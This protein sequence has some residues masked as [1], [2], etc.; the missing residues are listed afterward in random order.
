MDTS[1]LYAL[2]LALVPD[3]DAAET[4]FATARDEADLRRRAAAWREEQGLPPAAA[5]REEQGLPPAAADP[6]LPAVHPDDL[7]HALRRRVRLQRT[8]RL[9]PWLL[10]GGVALVLGALALRLALPPPAP[11]GMAA[12]PVFAAASIASSPTDSGLRFSVYRV[13]AGPQQVEAWWE[14]S[15]PGAGRSGYGLKPELQPVND[16]R[17]LAPQSAR[18]QAVGNDRLLGYSTYSSLLP[19]PDSIWLHGRLPGEGAG[20][21]VRA[22]AALAPPATGARVVPLAFTGDLGRGAFSVSEVVLADHYTTLRLRIS[23][24]RL[25]AGFH[26]EVSTPEGT[27]LDWWG[28][29]TRGTGGAESVAVFGPAPAGTQTLRVRVPLASPVIVLTPRDALPTAEVLSNLRLSDGT[30][31]ARLSLPPER[32]A[33][34]TAVLSDNRSQ[35]LLM[36]ALT[37]VGRGDDGTRQ[38][39][40]IVRNVPGNFAPVSIWVTLPEPRNGEEFTLNLVP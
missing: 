32:E 28:Y 6:P 9:R 1:G 15:G 22:T 16:S 7:E 8:R 40:L 4:I 30:L 24:M 36:G 5:W 26:P 33:G 14:L 38:Y 12:D 39:D 35:R 3:E 27:V 29:L 13:T 10:A 20:W 21:S 34:D 31:T 18:T 17:L 25:S 11:R 2:A 19:A 23:G 37:A